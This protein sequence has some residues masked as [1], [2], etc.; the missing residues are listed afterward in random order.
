MLLPFNTSTVSNLLVA[1]DQAAQGK[2]LIAPFKEEF[3]GSPE[4]VLQHITS[5]NTHCVEPGVTED[6][7]YIEE[8][9]E[10][11]SDFDM[12][13]SSPHTAWL[14]DLHHYTYGNILIDASTVLPL[15]KNYNKFTTKFV[16]VFRNLLLCPILQ[17][18]L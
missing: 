18:C 5:F 6:F 8:V 7:S 3:D 17:K 16:I 15:L 2:A 9:N 11:P 12:N 14:S 10:P 1:P 4:D 13:D